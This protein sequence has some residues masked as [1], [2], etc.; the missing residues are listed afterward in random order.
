[1]S[2]IPKSFVVVA[3]IGTLA[4]LLILFWFTVFGPLFNRADYNN[5]NSSTQHINAIVQRFADDC[6]QIAE[7]NDP[8][9]KKAIEQ[10]IYQMA[11]TVDVKSMQMPDGVRSCVNQAINGVTSGK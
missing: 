5:Y 3:S 8:T 10:D 4:L 7:T 6:Q 11:S 9:A 2:D 1:M